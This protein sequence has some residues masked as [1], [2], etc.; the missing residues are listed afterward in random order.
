[1]LTLFD[2]TRRIVIVNYDLNC[3]DVATPILR[4]RVERELGIPPAYL[5]LLE[6]WIAAWVQ[7]RKGPNRVGIGKIPIGSG[8]FLGLRIEVP[9]FVVPRQERTWRQG[10]RHRLPLCAGSVSLIL[11][12]SFLFR[13]EAPAEF[14]SVESY[15]F[16]A[17][18]LDEIGR[19]VGGW[20]KAI[21]NKNEMRYQ[22]IFSVH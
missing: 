15:G 19:M 17:G 8:R 5:V 21:A 16:A 14:L 3:L 4:E 9:A 10:L 1:M 20:R 7:D 6:R 12:P 22:E 11:F 18:L 2:G 13:G